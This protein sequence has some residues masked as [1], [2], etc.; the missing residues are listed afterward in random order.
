[1]D[2]L[3]ALWHLVNFFAPAAGVSVIAAV[4]VKLLWRRELAAV[5]WWRLIAW[6]LASTC[7]TL[8][9]GLLFLGHDGRM[10]T[11]GALVLACAL[12]LWWAAF[13]LR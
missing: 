7:V 11:Y 13:G 2:P 6:P 9:A 1:M 10:L 12:G 8:C 4:A 3:D 5:P